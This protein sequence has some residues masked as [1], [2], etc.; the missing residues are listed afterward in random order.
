[1]RGWIIGEPYNQNLQTK[2]EVRGL[3]MIDIKDLFGISS[4]ME[5]SYIE[6][7][8]YLEPVNPGEP[9]KYD[10]TGL[11][12]ETETI[13][14]VKIPFLRLPVTPGRNLAVLIE[15][16]ALNQ[17]LT[18]KNGIS[19]SEAVEKRLIAARKA[20]RKKAALEIKNTE[21]RERGIENA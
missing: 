4:I 17:R 10:R 13:M 7:S 11:N 3:G 1:M 15:V 12:S 21:N 6:M 18:N 5:E 9:W 19:T 14:G 16:A 2:M 8:V 20:A